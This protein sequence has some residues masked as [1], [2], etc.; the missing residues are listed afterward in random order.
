MSSF[1][2]SGFLSQEWRWNGGALTSINPLDNSQW[3]LDA[4]VSS[5]CK[6]IFLRFMFIHTYTLTG[7]NGVQMKIYQ[8]FSG[9]PQQTWTPDIKSGT[10]KLTTANFC[11]DLT[12]GN[13][14][15]GN[16]LQIWTC[17]SVGNNQ[18]W[19]A[20]SALKWFAISFCYCILSLLYLTIGFL[21]QTD[22]QGSSLWLGN[23]P[24]DMIPIRYCII[25]L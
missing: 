8:C 12:N 2:C 7:A 19:I 16:V 11:L 14:T 17:N 18:I 6:Y 25:L 5:Q 21:V 3:C 1:D 15:N 24:N 22:F 4:G 9:L 23:K 13:T 10:I 20:T